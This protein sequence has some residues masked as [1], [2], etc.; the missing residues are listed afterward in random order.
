MG[1]A[2]PRSR[3]MI[4]ASPADPDRRAEPGKAVDRTR[5]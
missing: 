2:S 3:S 5:P 4:P 1:L